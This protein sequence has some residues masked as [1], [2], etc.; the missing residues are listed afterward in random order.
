MCPSL[1]APDFI[2][3]TEDRERTSRRQD[4]ENSRLWPMV[5]AIGYLGVSVRPGQISDRIERL[6]Q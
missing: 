3:V 4:C 6:E 5:E 2:D 1:M